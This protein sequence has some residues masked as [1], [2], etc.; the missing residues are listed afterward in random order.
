MWPR[1]AVRAAELKPGEERVRGGPQVGRPGEA[2]LGWIE[3]WAVPGCMLGKN[4]PEEK[5]EA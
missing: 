2:S 4:V 3:R 5:M 1:V